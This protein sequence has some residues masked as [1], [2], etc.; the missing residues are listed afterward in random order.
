[1]N[2]QVD[3]TNCWGTIFLQHWKESLKPL[4][5]IN[6]LQTASGFSPW[7]SL[8]A[9]W[10]IPPGNLKK[11]IA[12]VGDMR[13]PGFPAILGQVRKWALIAKIHHHTI[14][15]EIFA[16][17]SQCVIQESL[18]NCGKRKDILNTNLQ[19]NITNSFD[20]PTAN[21]PHL[22]VWNQKI[23]PHLVDHAARQQVKCILFP[24]LESTANSAAFHNADSSLAS[25]PWTWVWFHHWANYL[26]LFFTITS[27]LKKSSPASTTKVCPALA[28]PLKRAQ[29][30]TSWRWF[31]C[32]LWLNLFSHHPYG[33]FQK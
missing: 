32:L 30:C 3:I 29:T 20:P 1:M 11:D 8:W 4:I 21:D 25:I 26:M 23:L 24:I 12:N 27:R 15:N 18:Q 14:A 16:C 17:L 5:G 33:C 2:L 19:W 13:R 9:N 6:Y 7:V 28:P 10:N 22:S 31:S